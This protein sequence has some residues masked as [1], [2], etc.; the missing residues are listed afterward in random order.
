P[1]AKLPRAAPHLAVRSL[2]LSRQLMGQEEPFPD[3]ERLN[4]MSEAD[5]AT[6]VAPLFEGAP[7]FLKRLAKKRPFGFEDELIGAARE[8][9]H[10]MPEE[11][12]LELIAAHPRIGAD[13]ATLSPFSQEEQGYGL[14]SREEDDRE[15]DE[16]EP[17]GEPAYVGEELAML[18][19]IYEA[20]F[21]FRYVVFVAGRPRE[22]IISLMEVALRNDRE[23]ELRRAIDDTIYIAADRLAGM[24]E[25]EPAETQI[26]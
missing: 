12:Q 22:A 3:L 18:N 6:A 14:D 10:A 2:Y 8:T 5:F 25:A 19:E 17:P 16:E 11:E 23:A 13:P 9:A 26:G 21:G 24:R 7:R 1:G 15:D 20:H 4:A